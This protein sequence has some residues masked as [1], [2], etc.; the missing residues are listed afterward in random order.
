M[1][2]DSRFQGDRRNIRE[3]EVELIDIDGKVSK[4]DKWTY[5][6]TLNEFAR[7]ALRTVGTPLFKG[8]V[9]KLKMALSAVNSKRL[10]LRTMI[11]KEWDEMNDFYNEDLDYLER[12]QP[13]IIKRSITED[14]IEEKHHENFLNFLLDLATRAGFTIYLIQEEPRVGGGGVGFDDHIPVSE[15]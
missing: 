1:V 2:R 6:Y 8:W 3:A 4:V 15:A 14:W 12:V 7:N 10:P 13:H 5:N 11:D 9:K